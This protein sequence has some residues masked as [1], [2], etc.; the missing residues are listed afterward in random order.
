MQHY[1]PETIPDDPYRVVPPY[2]AP[3]E[4]ELREPSLAEICAARQDVESEVMRCLKGEG[5]FRAFD[6]NSRVSFW[7]SED[8]LDVLTNQLST[9]EIAQTMAALLE[10]NTSQEEQPF[11]LDVQETVYAKAIRPFVEQQADRRLESGCYEDGSEDW[12]WDRP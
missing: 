10:C 9:L 4:M 3:G 12:F 2:C 8:L 6:S 11:V 7:G 5:S 1:T